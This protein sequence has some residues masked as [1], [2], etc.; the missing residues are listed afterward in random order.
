MGIQLEFGAS[1]RSGFARKKH[2]SAEVW[3]EDFGCVDFPGT[4]VPGNLKSN[5]WED[6][7]SG[8]IES[9]GISLV[10]SGEWIADL[11]WAHGFLKREENSQPQRTP[12][13]QGKTRR[14]PGEDLGK[15]LSQTPVDKASS[16]R[17]RRECPSYI[18]FFAIAQ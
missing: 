17:G 13:T 5:K 10:T 12:G 6:L 15:A 18:S 1:F 14:R 8:F 2:K 16:E 3:N 7:L 4:S 9:S 11:L